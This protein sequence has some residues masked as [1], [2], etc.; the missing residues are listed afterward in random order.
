MRVEE[1]RRYRCG[2]MG[3]GPW[4]QSSQVHVR[5][6]SF[7]DGEKMCSSVVCRIFFSSLNFHDASVIRLTSTKSSSSTSV[8]QAN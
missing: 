4:C 8:K 1:S 6:G 7:D 2:G 5:W 3:A